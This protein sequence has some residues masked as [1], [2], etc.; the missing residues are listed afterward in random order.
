MDCSGSTFEL[1]LVDQLK[2]DQMVDLFEHVLLFSICI[3][4]VHLKPTKDTGLDI[5]LALGTIVARV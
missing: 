5:D 2:E 3:M 4:M 1:M